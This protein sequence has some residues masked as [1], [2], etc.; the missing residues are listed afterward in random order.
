MEYVKCGRC[1]ETTGECRCPDPLEE[2]R[3]NPPPPKPRLTAAEWLKLNEADRQAKIAAKLR[4][5]EEALRRWREAQ[6]ERA[7]RI[8]GEFLARIEDGQDI[9]ESMPSKGLPKTTDTTKEI[10]DQVSGQ[11]KS[12]GFPVNPIQINTEV[13]CTEV[14]KPTPVAEELFRR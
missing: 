8:V 10:N 9:W 6:E 12:L 7:T 11:L 3:P 2:D 5:E 13:F 4:A 1:G 14:G